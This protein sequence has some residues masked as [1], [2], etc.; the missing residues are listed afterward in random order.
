MNKISLTFMAALISLI[1]V[2]KAYAQSPS[3]YLVCQD[4]GGFKKYGCACGSGAG[5]LSATGHFETSWGRCV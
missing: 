4:I 2:P 5:E 1:V 3:D